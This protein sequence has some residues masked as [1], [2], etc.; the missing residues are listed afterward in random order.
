MST[1]PAAGRDGVVRGAMMAVRG[2]FVLAILLGL[3]M[4]FSLWSSQT[5][6]PFHIFAG[7]LTL[8]GILV[9]LV[10]TKAVTLVLALLIG[11][12]GAVVAISHALASVGAPHLLMMLLAVGL[13]EM[14]VA[15]LKKKA[16]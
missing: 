5:V 10:R 9:A 6:L 12:L 15:K 8:L 3:G 14:T 7:G 2:G 11:L 4:W 1:M 16:A 13:A